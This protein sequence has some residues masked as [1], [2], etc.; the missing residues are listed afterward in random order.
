MGMTQTSIPAG[1]MIH[2]Y[3]NPNTGQGVP[4]VVIAEE[5]GT[6][7]IELITR[8][9]GVVSAGELYVEDESGRYLG[10]PRS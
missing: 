9:R 7:E 2:F 8:E 6:L 3:T 10:G 1:N 4:C 5:D